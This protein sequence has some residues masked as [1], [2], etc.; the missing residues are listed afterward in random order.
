MK[1]YLIFGFVLGLFNSSFCFALNGVGVM[2]LDGPV[3]YKHGQIAPFIDVDGMTRY[4]AT[5]RHGNYGNFEELTDRYSSDLIKG[6]DS[7]ILGSLLDSASSSPR[8][9]AD[10]RVNLRQ[11]LDAYFKTH[12]NEVGKY[13]DVL[14]RIKHYLHGTH[15]AG[16]IVGGFRPGE[17]RLISVPYLAKDIESTAGEKKE[18]L[19]SIAQVISERE[20]GVANLSFGSLS[21]ESMEENWAD[22]LPLFIACRDTIFV[23]AVGNEGSD[24]SPAL[25]DG[26]VFPKSGLKNVLFVGA[27]DE[28]GKLA[29]YSN[30]GV[31][32]V[33]IVT[34]GTNRVS[35]RSGGGRIHD[36]GTSMSAPLVTHKLAEIRS[37]H[38][39][40]NAPEAIAYL[41]ERESLKSENL[42]KVI[43]GG[44]Y[45]P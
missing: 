2:V 40:L 4:Y 26:Q 23:L 25:V 45:L 24:I 44:R 17:V 15:V 16:L 42:E 31:G 29:K 7:S 10:L 30:Y 28:D 39:E 18:Y 8:K 9:N 20:V 27:Q 36:T 19:D 34:Y 38:P 12:E 1:N 43:T 5:D 21:F 37:D 33:D 14:S 22:L 13:W 32:I 35:A 11:K 6:L 41:L 3:D